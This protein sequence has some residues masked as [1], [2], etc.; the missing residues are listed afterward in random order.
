MSGLFRLLQQKYSPPQDLVDSNAFAGRTILIT[1]A[2]TG[3]GLEAAKKIVTKGARKLIVTARDA[4]KG[5]KAKSVLQ[6]AARA[7][8]SSIQFSVISLS[9][10]STEDV[11]S[12]VNEIRS[13]H[14]DLDTAILNAGTIQKNWMQ[15]AE[16]YEET[17]QVNTISTVLLGLLILPILEQ[18][19]TIKQP[20]HL[21]FVSSGNAL[22]VKAADF[23][24]FADT[25][26]LRAMSDEKAWS[27]G[28]VQYARS[29]L[30]LEYAMRRI[31]K[32]PRLRTETGDIKVIVNSVC[33]GMCKSDLGRQ[34]MTNIF[35]TAAVWILF[36]FF[37]R[38][39]EQGSN[40]YVSAINRAADSQ[41]H[42]WKDDTY[43]GGGEMI[44]PLPGEKLGDKTWKELTEVMQKAEPGVGSI[45][46]SK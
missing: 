5:Q 42:I 17:I 33:P 3:L 11:K 26:V 45:L 10:S 19:S 46:E 38:T 16:R 36:T 14:P 4:Q 7:A 39:A 13:R 30:L 22:R 41:G 40:S 24:R 15:S 25:E 44:G 8:N 1:G 6:E 9:M 28:Q 37:A 43:Y 20:A 21:T 12:F 18:S 34:F 2:T 35:I 27:G 23:T 32:L 29:K 31:A